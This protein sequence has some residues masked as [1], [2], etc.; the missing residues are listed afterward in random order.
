MTWAGTVPKIQMGITDIDDKIIN[1]AH[2]RK[3]AF[4]EIACEFE[5]SFIEDLHSLGVRLPDTFSRVSDN[6]D[7]I[8]SFVSSLIERNFAYIA[9][10]GSVYFSLKNYS[11]K[12]FVYPKFR[13]K[14]SLESESDFGESGKQHPS[15]FA[16]WKA[17]KNIDDPGWDAPW[18]RGRPG[19]HIECS[20]MSIQVF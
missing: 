4:K 20:A 15:D 12:G 9:R 11:A 5:Q 18:G 7:A 16:L 2:Q 10:D 14:I 19:W 8:M 3:L 17:S 1:R 6:I 13:P